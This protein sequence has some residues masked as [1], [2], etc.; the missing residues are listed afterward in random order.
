MVKD[1]DDFEVEDEIEDEDDVLVP[2]DVATYPSDFTLSGIHEMWNNKDIEIP[3]FQRGFVWK[4][5]QSS[6][7]ID[8]FLLGLPVPLLYRWRA[9]E[10]ASN[11]Y[12]Q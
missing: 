2:F 11:E 12:N 8:S 9:Q 5:K 4:I 1:P 6:L 7:L 10:P 3:D